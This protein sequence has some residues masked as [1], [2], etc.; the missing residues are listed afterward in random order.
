M[1]SPAQSSMC[2]LSP[3]SFILVLC[4]H[5]FG[6]FYKRV[7]YIHTPETF[8]LTSTQ[9]SSNCRTKFVFSFRSWWHSELVWFIWQWP[10]FYVFVFCL[11]GNVNVVLCSFSCEPY[12]GDFWNVCLSSSAIYR[13]VTQG[14]LKSIFSIV[15]RPLDAKIAKL[16][17]LIHFSS[18][19]IFCQNSMTSTHSTCISMGII[20]RICSNDQ[21]WQ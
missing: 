18:L 7:L 12:S 13:L 5:R 20:E 10:V 6:K 11:S 1:F 14:P 2:S 15:G 16:D 4:R 17:K 9:F 19:Q 8:S 3:N 21:N